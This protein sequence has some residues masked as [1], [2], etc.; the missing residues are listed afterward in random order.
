MSALAPTALTT[1]HTASG[2]TWQGIRVA[3]LMGALKP[4]SRERVFLQLA[5]RLSREGAKV[6]LLVPGPPGP[7]RDLIPA[8]VR[9]IDLSR[10]WSRLPGLGSSNVA[11][12]ALSPPVIAAYL[13][14]EKPQALLTLS[15][16]PALTALAAQSVARSPTRIILRQ[17]N[18]IRIPGSG[19]YGHIPPRWRDRLIARWYGRADAVIAVSEGV[20]DN[21]QHLTGLPANRIHT[22]Y[23][24]VMLDDI[25]RQSIEPIDHPWFAPDSAPVILAVGRLVEKKDYPT[26]LR[27]FAI[28][29]QQ[30]DAR[31]VIL[32]EG[33]D[34]GALE[35]LCAE[36]GLKGDVDF[37][38]RKT[39]PFAYMAHAA[40]YVLSSTF[41]GMPSAP[42]EALACGCPV[43]STDCPSGPSE[44]LENGRFG[45]LVAVGDVNALAQAML[46]TLRNPPDRARQQ[47]R[48][49]AFPAAKTVDGYLDVLAKTVGLTPS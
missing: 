4:G 44:I 32:G 31:L 35:R 43:V 14:R 13:R 9:L 42:I 36:L 26:L 47:A 8:A 7:L 10:W 27:A 24:G 2:G 48:G 25:A 6:D 20:A 46:A 41:E 15:I 37:A 40:L 49:Q 17:S 18:V 22:V 28:V 23:N 11:R 39:N 1:E 21:L 16:P 5:E 45:A 38:G 34:R 30:H 29:R 12:L 3:M 33:P 19:R